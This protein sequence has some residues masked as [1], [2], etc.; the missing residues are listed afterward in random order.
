MV[1]TVDVVEEG[2]AGGGERHGY[3]TEFPAK[4]VSVDRKAKG[5][6]E[7][8]VAEA[9]TNDADPVLSENF[10]NKAGEF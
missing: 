2:G 7:N 4:G 5:A 1:R 3:D 10:P 9:G 6:A 8:L